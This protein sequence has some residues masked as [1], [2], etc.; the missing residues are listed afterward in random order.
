[1]QSDGIKVVEEILKTIRKMNIVSFIY[2]DHAD[3]LLN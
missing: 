1:M 3:S 2:K